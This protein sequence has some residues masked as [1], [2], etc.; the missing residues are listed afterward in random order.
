[1]DAA[2]DDRLARRARSGDSLLVGYYVI[3][4]HQESVRLSQRWIQISP[5]PQFAFVFAI[6]FKQTSPIERFST[7]IN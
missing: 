5:G 3:Q 1:M 7:K 2:H 6:A 4:N